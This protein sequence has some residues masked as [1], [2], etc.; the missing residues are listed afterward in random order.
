MHMLQFQ[1]LADEFIKVFA[2]EASRESFFILFLNA[3]GFFLNG[4]VQSP[5]VFF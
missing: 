3:F 4:L 2:C 5:D 1:I